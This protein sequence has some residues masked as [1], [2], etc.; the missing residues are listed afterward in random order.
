MRVL[1]A[2]I[3]VYVAREILATL[4]SSEDEAGMFLSGMC[5]AFLI[6]IALLL[7]VTMAWA[8]ARGVTL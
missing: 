8:T 5:W 7:L 2:A 3:V 1:A 4:P 6:F